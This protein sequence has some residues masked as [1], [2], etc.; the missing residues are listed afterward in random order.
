MNVCIQNPIDPSQPEPTP[1]PEPNP[2]PDPG[3]SPFPPD[4]FPPPIPP[5]P[6][7]PP[8]PQLIATGNPDVDLSARISNVGETRDIA[9]GRARESMREMTGGQRKMIAEKV[10]GRL[11][12]GGNAWTLQ[13]RRRAFA[14]GSIL[15]SV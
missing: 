15:K 14:S 7:K 8:I 3:P 13:K 2:N 4:P 5:Q 1:F 12:Q 11:R 9:S 6:V 10:V